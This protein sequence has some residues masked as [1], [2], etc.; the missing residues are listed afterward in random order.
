MCAGLED[1]LLLHASTEVSESGDEWIT[2]FNAELQPSELQPLKG[3]MQKGRLFIWMNACVLFHM[4]PMIFR[5]K[6]KTT[7]GDQINTVSKTNKHRTRWSE[8]KTATLVHSQQRN[9]GALL[10]ASELPGGSARPV[11]ATQA[12]L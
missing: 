9:T 7:V 12:A 5:S 11:M 6:T 4:I 3:G 10:S 1:L 8:R 2:A